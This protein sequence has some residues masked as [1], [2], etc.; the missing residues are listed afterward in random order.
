MKQFS[1]EFK[2]F[3]QILSQRSEN[4]YSINTFLWSDASSLI[5]LLHSIQ[6]GDFESRVTACK[7]MTPL[8]FSMDA[9]NYKKWSSLDIAIKA[10]LYPKDLLNLYSQEGVWRTAL[11][12]NVG[13]W[14]PYDQAH[15]EASDEKC[16]Q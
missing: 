14:R 5:Q 8:F 9:V 1:T 12:Q 6:T 3:I 10:S 2:K 7:R 15:E 11:S 13:G 4:F 16:H